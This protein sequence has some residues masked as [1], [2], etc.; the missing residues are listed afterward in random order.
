MPFESYILRLG[1]I[2]NESESNLN[3][4]ELIFFIDTDADEKAGTGF[5]PP[6]IKVCHLVV[7]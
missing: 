6:R 4:K 5:M 3:N 7:T 1:M 2:G